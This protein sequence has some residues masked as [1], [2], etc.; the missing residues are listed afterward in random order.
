M[1]GVAAFAGQ[2][3]EEV[4]R[5]LPRLFELSD[6]IGRHPE[7]GSE[8]VQSSKML[9]DE[10]EMN[11][12]VV[13]RNLLGMSTAFKASHRGKGV[14]P[15]IAF[16]AEYDALPG[17]GHGCGHNI[18]GTT[19]VG[20]GIV[21]SRLME[22]SGEVIVLGTPAEEGRGPYG[23]AKV[24]MVEAGVFNDVDTAMMV[25]PTSGGH[26]IGLS[27]LAVGGANIVF[28]GKTSHAAA[29]PHLGLNA[30]NAAT[31]MYMAVHAN[32][33]QLRRD[34]NPVIHGIITEGGL[35]SN[36]IPD[37][38]TLQF[39]VRSSDEGYVPELL[40]IVENS[41]R[42][43]ALATGCQVEI[44][45]R[46]G[47]RSKLRNQS[48]EKLFTGIF[49]DLG[50]ELED[51]AITASRPPQASTDFGDVTHVTPGITVMISIAPGGVPGH[52][53]E[54]A[55]ATFTEEGHQGLELVTKVLSI[56]GL[57]LLS[58]SQQV[59]TIRKEHEE[60]TRKN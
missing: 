50:V 42:G 36:I 53:R 14:G 18:I 43:A 13:E 37:R 17:I 60:R 19:A 29:D 57:K 15:R 39:G 28:H 11:G 22:D 25:H 35:A 45:S 52:S 59:K 44:T 49:Q 58:D 34:A 20:A 24:R 38:A 33:Q 21:V 47:L 23:G 1:D 9:A 26:R 46:R 7:L 8:E 48:L 31:L 54:L 5:L 40:K 55:D 16:L 12:F 10:L 27:A 56:A 3:E 30:L 4:K 2:V 32:R 41:A 51:T 6:W